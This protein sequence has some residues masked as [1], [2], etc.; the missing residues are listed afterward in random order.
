MV[1]R[2]LVRLLI[3]SVC[4]G[5]TACEKLSQQG[6]L[7][8]QSGPFK[9]AIPAEYGKLVGATPSEARGAALLWFE[10]P[11]QIRIVFVDYSMGEIGPVVTSIP[12]R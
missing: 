4:I 5:A 10:A 2:T 7:V 11:D 8:R 9:D 1:N 3:V 6:Q 12:R